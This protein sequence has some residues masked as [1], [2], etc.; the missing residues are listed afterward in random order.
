[1]PCFIITHG[2]QLPTLHG[3]CFADLVRLIRTAAPPVSPR[4]ANASEKVSDQRDDPGGY[5]EGLDME[6]MAMHHG[7]ISSSN[8]PK[9]ACMWLITKAVRKY[10]S[11]SKTSPMSARA[12]A[13]RTSLLDV[14]LR[15]KFA[16]PAFR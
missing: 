10:V 8:D 11:I 9:G 14:T 12:R 6:P 3:A 2:K 4:G 7:F 15:N 1:V 16:M 5:P 13:S